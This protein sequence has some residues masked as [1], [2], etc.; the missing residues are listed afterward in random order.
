MNLWTEKA[1]ETHTNTIDHPKQKSHWTTQQSLDEKFDMLHVDVSGAI[2]TMIKMGKL[3]A[4]G[5][6]A[7]LKS[8]KF[9]LFHFR[10]L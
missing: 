3:N 8:N 9:Q 10:K 6:L 7:L 5:L 2:Q 1:L 4:D